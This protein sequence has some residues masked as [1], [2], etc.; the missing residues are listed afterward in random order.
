MNP[1]ECF[2]HG[3][4]VQTCY[5]HIK[6]GLLAPKVVKMKKKCKKLKYKNYKLMQKEYYKRLLEE[7]VVSRQKMLNQ[8]FK[9]GIGATFERKNN[10][11]PIDISQYPTSVKVNKKYSKI[12]KDVAHECRDLNFSSDDEDIR[13]D[14]A[15]QSQAKAINLKHFLMMTINI[16]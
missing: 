12:L 9:Y 15:E 6:N 1:E 11:Y 14:V 16:Y 13:D 2:K 8:A 4:P 3:N 7:I 10:I 5:H